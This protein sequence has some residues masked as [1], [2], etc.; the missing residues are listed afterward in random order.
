MHET[1][2][3]MNLLVGEFQKLIGIPSQTITYNASNPFWISQARVKGGLR[4][5]ATL[6]RSRMCNKSA[7]S[8]AAE[9]CISEVSL[10]E[11][12]YKSGY[13]MDIQRQKVIDSFNEIY[14]VVFP[15]SKRQKEKVNAAMLELQ[16]YNGSLK[17]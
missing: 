7:I 13:P 3:E 9:D 16:K 6:N 1:L 10:L 11:A 4:L 5:I 2:T 15:P 12:I 17:P 14:K 8:N